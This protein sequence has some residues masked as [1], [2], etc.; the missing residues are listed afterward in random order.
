M[1]F[2][3]TQFDVKSATVLV[4]TF[5]LSTSRHRLPL[6][7]IE[8]AAEQ[9]VASRC[10]RRRHQYVDVSPNYLGLAVAEE[11]LCPFAPGFNAAALV[12]CDDPIYDV[13]EDRI[14]ANGFV[15]MRGF[16]ILQRSDVGHRDDVMSPQC[17]TPT[18]L[19]DSSVGI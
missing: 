15:A 3:D 8:L 14:Q 9:F 19:Q 10:V 18:N 5:D 13:V 11:T 4:D 16:G 6:G 17:R 1:H 7:R 2:A 12:E